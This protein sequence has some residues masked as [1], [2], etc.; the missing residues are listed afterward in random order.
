MGAGEPLQEQQPSFDY[1]TGLA[2]SSSWVKAHED[3]AIAYLKAHIHAHHFIRKEPLAAAQLIHR[4]TGF[5]IEVVS[6]VIARVRWDASIYDRDLAAL[7]HLSD[8]CGSA[9]GEHNSSAPIIMEQAYLAHAAL[10][11]RLPVPTL[12]GDWTAQAL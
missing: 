11:L 1:L 5:P 9:A 8:E 12:S 10:A 7:R 6:R 3:A 2:A 4:A